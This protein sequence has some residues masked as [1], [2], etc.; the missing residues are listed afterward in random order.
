M[1]V[2]SG[3]NAHLWQ[4][5]NLILP[6][7]ARLAFLVILGGD[8]TSNLEHLPVFRAPHEG[9]GRMHQSTDA[10]KNYPRANS[11]KSWMVQAGSDVLPL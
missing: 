11:V 8:D 4:I 6:V 3:G 1:C 10:K 5:F 7:E 9:D 2:I